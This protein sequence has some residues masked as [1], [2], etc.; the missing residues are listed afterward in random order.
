VQTSSLDIEFRLAAPDEWKI[1]QSIAHATWPVAYGHL[2][3]PA[4]LEYMLDV[5][6]NEQSIR[7]QMKKG[8]PFI[9]ACH[10]NEP[11]GFASIEKQYK[12]PTSL[13][14]HKLY[15][16]PEFHGKGIGKA[17]VDYIA[18]LATQTGH[19]AVILKV[20]FKNQDALRFYQLQG[21]RSIGEEE[22]DVGNGYKVLD[23]IMTKKI[24]TYTV[25][26]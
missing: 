3:P 6:Y 2:L 22:T 15:V 20:F 17:F 4:Q 16:L 26:R 8:Q 23:Y 21:F 12:S 18:G 5:I 9:L 11:L 24:S 1:I 13:M 7:K 14:I 10:A 19:D 25:N